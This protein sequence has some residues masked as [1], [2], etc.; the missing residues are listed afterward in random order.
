MAVTNTGTGT[1]NGLAIGTI[2]YG[3]GASGWL[4][5]S[6]D[7]TTAPATVTLTPTTGALAAG[8]YTATVPVT[9]SASGVTNSPQ[10]IS[11]TFTVSAATTPAIRTHPDQPYVQRRRRAEGNP[12]AQ[13]VA[14]TNS[15]IGTLSGL[16]IG[17]I[18]YGAGATGWL[19]ASLDVTTAPATVTLTPTTGSL[20]AGTYTATVPVTSTATGVTNSPQNISVTFTVAAPTGPTIALSRRPTDVLGHQGASSPA[21]QTVSVTNTGVER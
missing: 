19:A 9:S 3:A 13:T 16:A 2:T 20:A 4:A 12:A 6:L 21:A 5:A 8:T 7:V 14:V 18:T 17:T 15:G 10:N 1:L 11:V